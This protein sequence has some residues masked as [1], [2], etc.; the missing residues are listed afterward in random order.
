MNFRVKTA[1]VRSL[2]R[3]ILGMW[4]LLMIYCPSRSDTAVFLLVRGLQRSLGLYSNPWVLVRVSSKQTDKIFG[5]N[6]NKTK[7]DLFQLCFGLFHKTE[8]VSVCFV[9]P[10]TN[11]FSF[12]CFEPISKQL[13][14]TELFQNKP[15]QTKTTLN[16]LQKY[17]NRLSIKLF[18]LVFCLFGFNWNIETLCF[19]TEAKHRHKLFRNKTK[20]TETTLNFLKKIPKYA[21]FRL[22]YS[23]FRFNQNTKTFCFGME[24]KQP[25]QTFCFGSCQN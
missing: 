22:L 16:F 5:S 17:R 18:R 13:K 3:V 6:Q 19:G 7:K 25:K 8:N 20:Q 23:L 2:K 21:L 4:K 1:P 15:K 12:W 14:Q 24:P 11:N 9:K 10:K